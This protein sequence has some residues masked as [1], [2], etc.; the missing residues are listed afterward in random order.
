MGAKDEREWMWHS[1]LIN[2]LGLC[3]WEQEIE[4][5]EIRRICR[6][7]QDQRRTGFMF[8]GVEEIMG[9][10][11]LPASLV[12]VGELVPGKYV[13]TLDALFSP[14]ALPGGR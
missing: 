10:E 14:I 12:I 3:A 13:K 1:G 11:T 2:G 5:K 9:V 7:L 8:A 4:G 6:V